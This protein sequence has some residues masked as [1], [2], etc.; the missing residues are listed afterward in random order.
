MKTFS[1][2][3]T[4]ALLA[5]GIALASVSGAAAQ[6]GKTV[7]IG[8][9]A[10][11]DA[12]FVTK[13]A[14]KILEDR[15]GQDVELIQTDIAPQYQGVAKGDIDAMLMS[16]QPGT[17]ADYMDKVGKDVVNLSLLYGNASLGWVVPNYIPEDELSSIEDLKKDA[18][19]E[20]L[21]GKIQGIDP[22]AG[23]MRLSGEAIEAYGLDYDLVSASGA[24]MTAALDRAIK[25]EEWIVVTG[26]RPHWMFG[27]YDL[28][29]LDDPK[30]SLGA[31]E[32]VH[33]VARKG[34]YQENPAAAMML[35][36]FFLP[37][38]DLE[39]A[40]AEA[41]ETSYEEAVDNYISAHPNR[42]EYWVSGKVAE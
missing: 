39:A 35:A 40:M 27:K 31:A 38:E 23:L 3:A 9:T 34:F 24:A 15:L 42:V 8:W 36:R 33:A 30:G 10:W 25:R 20:K 2:I 26:W 5:A 41:Q 21:D 29:Y 28:R 7:K 1:R 6:S 22:G 11:S 12:E 4:T 17:H 19:K 37:L 32:R 13:L 18:V 16:W 14:A